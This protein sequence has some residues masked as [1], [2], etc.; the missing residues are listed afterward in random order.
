MRGIFA[1]E[2]ETYPCVQ[3]QHH[4][5]ARTTLLPPHDCF[6]VV[7]LIVSQPISSRFVIRLWGESVTD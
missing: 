4:P 1:V 3:C 7:L 6:E 2:A 5:L